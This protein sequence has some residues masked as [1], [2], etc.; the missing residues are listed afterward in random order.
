MN[1]IPEYK[2]EKFTCPHCGIIA[3]QDWANYNALCSF[4]ADIYSHAYYDYRKQIQDYQQEAIEKFLTYMNKNFKDFLEPFIPRELSIVKC[5]SCNNVSL[6]MSE[7][8]VYPRR[9]LISPPN[10]DLNEDIKKLYFEGAL[11]LNDSPKGATALL[12]LAMQKLLIQIGKEGK[13]INSDIKDLVSDGLSPKVQKSLDLLRVIGNN[14]VHPGQINLDDNKDIAITLFKVLN[15][16]ADE[17]I[18]KPKE[19]DQLYDGILPPEAKENIQ[20]RDNKN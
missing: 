2:S 17:M 13:N 9:I 6:W 7:I 19:I 10:S 3:K 12:R 15:L 8:M 14:A 16:I 18:T 20:K 11:I 4:A 5:H 1:I